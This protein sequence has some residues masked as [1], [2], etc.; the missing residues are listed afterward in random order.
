MFLINH[1]GQYNKL[2]NYLRDILNMNNMY[3][4]L[5]NYLRDILNMNNMCY[6]ARH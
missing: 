5:A 2:S 6:Y 1:T 3:N 4:K